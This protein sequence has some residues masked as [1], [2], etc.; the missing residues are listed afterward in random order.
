MKGTKA[1]R[2]L[3]AAFRPQQA[4]L[5]GALAASLGGGAAFAQEAPQPVDVAQN[6]RTVAPITVTRTRPNL[7]EYVDPQ[8][9][10]KADYSASTKL[11]QPLLDTPKSVSVITEDLY[12]D[13]GAT[14]FR[15]LMRTQPGVTLGTGEGGNAYGDRI[16]IRGFDARND[17]YIDGVRDPGV[18]AREI[19]D[20]DQIEILKGPSSTIAGRGTTG[21]AVSLIS[22][23][24]LAAQLRRPRGHLRRRRHPPRHARRQPP[25]QRPTRK[26]G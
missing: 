21:G 18:G 3:R 16:F 24:P 8:A 22:K 12:D 1:P 20:I 17:I 23:Q 9:P 5:V 7:P 2:S 14:T 25:D 4:G 13:L 26:C 15:D 11:T 6:T 19:F 10:Y